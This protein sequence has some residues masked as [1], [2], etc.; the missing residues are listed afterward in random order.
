M[1]TFREGPRMI[2]L[3]QRPRFTRRTLGT[4]TIGSML[5]LSACESSLLE[6]HDPDIILTA[7]SAAAAISIKNGVLGYFSGATAGGESTFFFGGLLTDEWRSGDTFEQRNSADARLVAPTNSFLGGQL[8]ALMRVRVQG[9]AAINALRQFSPTPVS[10]IGLMF[11]LTA[12]AENQ[13]GESYCNGIPFSDV[14]DGVIVY[15]APV[16]VDSAFKR[17]INSADSALLN[18][19]GTDAPRIANLAAVVKG[20]ALL[21][22]AQYAAAATAVTAVPTSFIYQDTHSDNASNNQIW[23]LNTSAKRYVVADNEGGNGL[24]F[25]SANDPR[26]PTAGTGNAFDANTPFVNTTL[27]AK[28]DPVTIVSGIEARLIEAEAA[29]KADNFPLFVSKL[30][31]ARATKASLT[32]LTDPGTPTTRADLLFR[33]R[34]FWM[35]GTG[36]RLGDLRRLIRQYGRAPETVFP[37]GPWFKGGSYGGDVNLPASFEELNNPNV[38][39]D[40]IK[41]SCIDRNA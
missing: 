1:T 33:E 4:M 12:W 11:A 41:V 10:N 30:N 13:I 19:G 2:A 34:A 25:K 22:R 9:R 15:G 39:Q 26:L 21:N 31:D 24:P 27:W 20:R 36:H 28:N 17:A 6:V 37:T 32:P 23:A 8:R 18:N 5:A 3:P 29:L 7:T 38:P 40:Q 35:F 16:G 14:N